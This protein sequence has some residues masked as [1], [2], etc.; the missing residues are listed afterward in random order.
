MNS[1]ISLPVWLFLLLVLLS[2]WALFDGLFVPGVRWFVRQRTNRIIDRVNTR[3]RIRIPPFELTRREVLI[4]R[5]IYHPRVM[6]TAEEYARAQGMPRDVVVAR[7]RRYAQEIVPAFN[8]YLYFRV[9]YAI[10]RKIARMLYRVR[11]GYS[12]E[13]GLA[14]MA[15]GATVVFVMNHRSNMDYILVGYLAAKRAALSYAVGEWARIWPLRSLI[16]SMG[17][18]FVRRKSGD[19]LYRRVLEV[20]VHMATV[21]GVTQA[22][23][24]EG[25][26]TRDGLLREPKLGLLDYMLRSFDPQGVKDVVFIPVGINY[27][28]T[29][30]DR[31]LLAE[32]DPGAPRPSR[33]TAVARTVR[34]ILHNLA[35]MA[36]NRWH[37]FGYACVNFGAPISAREFML[38]RGLDFRRMTRDER[39]PHMEAL[40]RTLMRAVGAVI[41]VLPV[42]VLATVLLRNAG[43]PL[44]SMELK[45][46]V[47]SLFSELEASGAHVYIPRRDREYAVEVGLRMLRLRHLVD[48][49]EGFLQARPTELP[50][51]RY[52]ANSIA[53]LLAGS[54][55]SSRPIQ[56]VLASPK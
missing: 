21:G 41:P 2:L 38:Q 22:V 5:V 47:Q 34:F 36:R 55:S 27:D 24:P 3:L 6:E 25:G 49:N 16:R 15:P 12:D 33:V 51:L 10:A 17:A 1:S 19:E 26:L 56:V 23:Y 11:L 8:A 54:A 31:T 46:Q 43:C 40:G 42:P 13:A 39:A 44:T 7:V 30:E 18:Y 29:L 45:S 28:R 9:G 35:L 52:Y 48:E 4:E 14:R 37:R 32:L 50:L 20:Y 53:H